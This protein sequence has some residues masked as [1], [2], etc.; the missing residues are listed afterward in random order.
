MTPAAYITRLI[1]FG[2]TIEPRELPQA[3]QKVGKAM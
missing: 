1:T 2:G 3:W